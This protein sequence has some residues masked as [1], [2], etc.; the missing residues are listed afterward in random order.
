MDGNANGTAPAITQ[1]KGNKD[2]LSLNTEEKLKNDI[3]TK[4]S[5]FKYVLKI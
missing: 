2:Q 1:V 3:Q 5:E 4:T